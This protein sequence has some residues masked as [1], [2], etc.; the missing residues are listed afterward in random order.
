MSGGARVNLLPRE[1]AAKERERRARTGVAV[2]GL[3]LLAVLGGLYLFQLSRVSDAENRLADAQTE[4]DALQQD[5]NR[6]QE[7]QAL[8]QRRDESVGIVTAAMGGEVSLAGVL[9]DIA[10]VMPSDAALTSLNI[11]TN[12]TGQERAAGEPVGPSWG[13]ITG[14]GETLG[15]HAPGVERFIIQF[16]K[17]AAFFNVHVGGSTVD[18]DGFATFSFET[19]LG[20][21]IFTGRYSNGL[22]ETLR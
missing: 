5:L 11:S 7:F 6:L 13:T 22:P 19:D 21:E 4:R 2:A 8:Q 3:A 15:R 14:S 18:D 1:V 16:D 10:A 9:Q 12:T 17:I 20:P